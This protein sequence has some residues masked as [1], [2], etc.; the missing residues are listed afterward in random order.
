MICMRWVVEVVLYCDD[1][2]VISCLD[3]T[4]YG[5]YYKMSYTHAS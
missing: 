2:R 1:V 3:T 5:I 4:K